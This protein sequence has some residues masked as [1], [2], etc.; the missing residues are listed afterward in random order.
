MGPT[1]ILILLLATAGPTK[2]AI[3]YLGLTK[4]TDAQFKRQLALRSAGIAAVLCVLFALLGAGILS[5]L[6]IS[7]EALLIAGGAILFVFALDMVIGEDKEQ[8]DSS[9]P[10]AP[11]LDWAAF[12]LAMPLMASPQGLVA[13]VAIEATSQTFADSLMLVGLILVVAVVN[14]VFMLGADRIFSKIPPAFLKV[15]MRIAGLLLCGLAV[16]IMIYGFDGL[17]LIPNQAV[18]L[19]S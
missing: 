4:N 17:G 19:H 15:I 12:P 1:E 5:T 18:E 3:V 8:A 9:E 6:K 10:P 13:I 7:V 2:A 14:V 11:T 16:Q